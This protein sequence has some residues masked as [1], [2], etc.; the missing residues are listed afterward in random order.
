MGTHTTTANEKPYHYYKCF[1]RSDYKRGIC[2]QKSLRAERAEAAIWSFVSELLKEPG[3]IR[4]GMD[5][6]IAEERNTKRGNPER[7]AQAWADEIAKCAR[8]RSAY[9]DQQAAGLMTFEELGSKLRELDQAR[10]YAERELAALKDSQT[11]VKELESDRD[12]LLESISGQLPE[13]LDRITGED[14][15]AIYRML[16]VE[17]TP[18]PEGFYE[19]TGAFCTAEPLSA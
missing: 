16:Q 17:I 6:L 8:L 5:G 3:R 14:R 2:E 9:Q 1:R 12:A 18:T 7:E 11:R 19:V 15:N 10:L 13:E 4:A